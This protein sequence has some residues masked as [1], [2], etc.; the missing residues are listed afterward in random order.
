MLD[1][2]KL[3]EIKYFCQEVELPSITAQ[4]ARQASPFTEIHLPGDKLVFGDLNVSF[5]VDSEMSNY[6][7]LHNWIIGLGFPED[8]SQYNQFM[9]S[10]RTGIDISETSA[11]CSDAILTVLGPASTAIKTVRFMNV[12]PVSLGRVTFASTV[13]DTVYLLGA[14]TFRYTDYEFV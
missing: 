12:F 2:I 11:A 6:I 10:R 7:A 8:Y 5:M 9:N 3:P 13:R 4:Y 1:I 14:A